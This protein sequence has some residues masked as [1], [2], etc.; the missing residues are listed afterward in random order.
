LWAAH[1]RETVS[2]L[3]IYVSATMIAETEYFAIA[4]ISVCYK[5]KAAGIIVPAA[6]N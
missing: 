2:K 3:S 1:I 4:M 5:K 6:Q